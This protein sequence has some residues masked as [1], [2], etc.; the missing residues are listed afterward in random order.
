[1]VVNI[2]MK[3]KKQEWAENNREKVRKSQRR[4]RENNR[5]KV[6]ESQKRYYLSHQEKIRESRSLHKDKKREYA[7]EYAKNNREKIKL[8][9]QKWR[10]NNREKIK[11]C[12][13]KWR[14]NNCE[15]IRKSSLRYYYKNK[16]GKIKMYKKENKEKIKGYKKRWSKNNKKK[17]RESARQSYLKNRERIREYKKR[18]EY[19]LISLI[20]KKK[21]NQANPEK[22]KVEN[23]AKRIPLKE[24]CEWCGSIEFLQRHHPD[25]SKP[26]YVITLCASCHAKTKGNYVKFDKSDEELGK[27]V[28]NDAKKV[29]CKLMKEEHGKV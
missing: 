14:E 17:E 12:K 23:I 10:E 25:Y 28:I 3:D 26:D 7:R 27:I 6:K 4:Y 5:E 1:M 22:I 9:K 18:P 8:C 2:K 15:K 19:R 24:K 20:S 16:N 29:G 13:Q 11:L 21:W